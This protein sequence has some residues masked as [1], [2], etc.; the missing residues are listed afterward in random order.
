[1]MHRLSCSLVLR[2]GFDIS[3]PAPPSGPSTSSR[4]VRGSGNDGGHVVFGSVPDIQPTVIVNAAARPTTGSPPEAEGGSTVR[5]HPSDDDVVAADVAIG[6]ISHEDNGPTGGGLPI[7]PPKVPSDLSVEGACIPSRDGRYDDDDF[8]RRSGVFCIVS[9][10]E[11]SATTITS[12]MIMSA[13]NLIG[14]FEGGL[15]MSD[16]P[17]GFNETMKE[18]YWYNGMVGNATGRFNGYNGFANWGL[19]PSQRERL[20]N[21][22]CHAEQYVLLR[23]LSPLFSSANELHESWLIDKTPSYF[24]KLLSVMDRTP[25]VPVIVTRKS[26]EA[27]MDSYVNKHG[28]D[29]EFV[30]RQLGMF[31]RELAFCQEKYPDRIHVVNHTE[32]LEDVNV[33][34][35][36]VFTFLGLQWVESYASLEGLRE[37][38]RKVEQSLLEQ[39]KP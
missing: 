7:T 9:G 29:V 38:V 28:W 5:Q 25:K 1:M 19:S 24:R 17:A 16:T 36:K 6:A 8:R 32:M 4:S 11:H 39:S 22:S 15:L 26:D 30:E 13:P 2:D 35:S 3:M 21:A 10:M 31:K 12:S 14:A 18:L 37:K 23:E 34:M 33:A 20:T 27:V